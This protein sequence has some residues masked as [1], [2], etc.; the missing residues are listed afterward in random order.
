MHSPQRGEL[1]RGA[2]KVWAAQLVDLSARN[3]LLY[4]RDL[5]VGTLDVGGVPRELLFDVLVGKAVSLRR[6]FPDEDGR[7]DAIK[8]A[9]TVRNR[10]QEHFEERGLETLYLACGMATWSNQ[11][12]TATPAAPLLL[13]PA[14]LAPRG[15]AQEEFELAVTGELE[16]NPT[17]LQMLQ[18]EFD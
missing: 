9:R 11:H 5:K 7:A 14:R 1:L 2:T 4:F 18:S 6:L 12:G 3:N 15:A 8:R 17:L 16:V 10:A 13:V